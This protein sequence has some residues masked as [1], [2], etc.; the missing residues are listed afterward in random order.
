MLIDDLM[1][2]GGQPIQPIL[3]IGRIR[4]RPRERQMLTRAS[5][6][7][8]EPL[9]TDRDFL[10]VLE[11][12]AERL[13]QQRL[14]LRP[15]VLIE[16]LELERRHARLPSRYIATPSTR[17]VT[18]GPERPSSPDTGAASAASSSSR[19]PVSVGARAA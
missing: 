4:P 15:A 12:L 16:L 18:S 2:F 14:E 5:I 9:A 17:R 19:S 8:G 7:L 6:Q 10:A 1:G 11:A 3:N 13:V